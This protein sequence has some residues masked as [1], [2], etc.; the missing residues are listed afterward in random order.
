M[1]IFLSHSTAAECWKS[2]RFD[3][4]LGGPSIAPWHRPAGAAD[5][6][7]FATALAMDHLDIA[8]AEAGAFA[9]SRAE[10]PRAC[11]PFAGEVR[12][13]RE[14]V[15]AFA[16]EPLHLL[17]PHK[18][19]VNPLKSTRC[20]VRSAPL[21]CG[22]FVRVG[23]DLL[24]GSP[25]L[26]FAQMAASLPFVSLVKL[27]TELCSLYTL[28]PNG[29]AGYE[30]VLPPTTP[31]A[32]EAYLGRCAGM[33]GLADARKAAR[34]V[35][36]SSGSP[37]ETALALILG[38]PLRLG[39][40]GLPRPILNHRIDALQSGPNAMERRYYLCDLYW[41]EARV[42]LEYDSDLEHTGPSRI[43]N[44]ARR[45]NDLTSLSVTTITATRD[46]VMDGRGL[47]RLAHQV[48]RALGARIRSERGWSTRARG[49]LFR[50]LVAS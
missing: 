33:R 16:S 8:C 36:A 10:A 30:R 9:G 28:Q 48:A 2:G 20:H 15:L 29:S 6:E 38:L 39:G 37:M 31:R 35:A 46:Q 4:L 26:C 47:D 11:K 43:A 41:P 45:R 17:V 32:L 42:A 44:D 14:G 1:A 22:S 25:E 34:L 5:V 24:L 3:A 49:E 27:G 18:N 23:D 21:P 7:R 12:R 13:L 19:A 50:S 40:Y